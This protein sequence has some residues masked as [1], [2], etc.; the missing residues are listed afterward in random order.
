MLPFTSAI[1]A[2]IAS[3]NPQA[4]STPSVQAPLPALA[5]ENN[6]QARMMT[7]SSPTPAM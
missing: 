2:S 1:A 7:A 5:R 4:A 3:T 6:G